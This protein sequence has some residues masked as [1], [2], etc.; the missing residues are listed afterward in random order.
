M[1][2]APDTVVLVQLFRHFS[3]EG[4]TFPAMNQKVPLDTAVHLSLF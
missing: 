1:D 2:E 3:V 4:V